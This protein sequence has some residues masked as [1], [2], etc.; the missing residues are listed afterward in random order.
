MQDSVQRLYSPIFEVRD[1]KTLEAMGR[2]SR[3]STPYSKLNTWTAC[4]SVVH[5]SH[6]S[7]INQ[8]G[9]VRTAF[10]RMNCELRDQEEELLKAKCTES[11]PLPHV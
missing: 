10:D 8:F 9:Q 3:R 5:R 11:T 7:D 2:E 4:S 6:Q 1:V